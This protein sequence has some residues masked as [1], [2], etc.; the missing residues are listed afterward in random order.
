MDGRA[1]KDL[2]WGLAAFFGFKQVHPGDGK[3][4]LEPLECD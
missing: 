4:V 3:V 2:A 1:D